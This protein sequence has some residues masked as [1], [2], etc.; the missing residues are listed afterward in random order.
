MLYFKSCPK[1]LTG[2]VEHN[3]DPYTEYLQCLNCGLMRDIPDGMNAVAA[4]KQIQAQ[5]R[6]ALEAEAAEEAV[7]AGGRDRAIA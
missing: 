2:T 4:L 1:C 6:E 7:A 3:R 5:F